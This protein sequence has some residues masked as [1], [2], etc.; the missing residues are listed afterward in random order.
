MNL[1]L[2]IQDK[3]VHIIGRASGWE[4]APFKRDAIT[5]GLTGLVLRRPVS[6]VIDIHDYTMLDR[7]TDLLK[8]HFKEVS[9][10]VNAL[11]IPFITCYKIPEIPTS[12]EYP[13]KK[14][15]R[16]YQTNYFNSS[17]DY[18]VALALYWGF[19]HICI[20]GVRLVDEEYTYQK[21]G[22]ES[23]L[24]FAKGLGVK[25]EV[26]GKSEIF[27]IPNRELYGYNMPQD[28]GLLTE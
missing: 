24:S 22:I 1:N 3:A 19:K 10:R 17:M 8:D 16:E 21:P 5:W 15:C 20:Y 2:N 14:I 18:A 23:W 28:D 9:K 27:K 6:V 13:L 7:E 12:Y 11:K 25:V 26:F 4:L